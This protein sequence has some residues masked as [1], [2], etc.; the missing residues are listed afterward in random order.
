MA[1]KSRET[2]GTKSMCSSW[3]L[4]CHL[5]SSDGDRLPSESQAVWD[6]QSSSA[7]FCLTPPPAPMS[8]E[9]YPLANGHETFSFRLRD[10]DGP[11]R[12]AFQNG[13]FYWL[14]APAHF[15]CLWNFF[16]MVRQDSRWDVLTTCLNAYP[17]IF[18]RRGILLE[19]KS[20]ANF[21][22]TAEAQKAWMLWQATKPPMSFCLF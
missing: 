1:G 16:A 17:L 3:D 4:D 2:R 14:T 20:K 12:D 6:P 18:V 8:Q 21:G 9:T 10:E 15:V 11:R 19:E 5:C 7:S 22:A 13:I